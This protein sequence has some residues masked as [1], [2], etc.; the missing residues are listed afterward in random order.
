MFGN[1][2]GFLNFWLHG[3]FKYFLWIPL[4]LSKGGVPFALHAFI[5]VFL[6]WFS[7]Y[8][9]ELSRKNFVIILLLNYIIGYY[10]W[11]T[12]CPAP[13]HFRIYYKGG[14]G[15]SEFSNDDFEKFFKIGYALGLKNQWVICGKA[16]DEA[17]SEW[18]FL[19]YSQGLADLGKF[20]YP[21]KVKPVLFDFLISAK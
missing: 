13:P 20:L 1:Q 5:L 17:Q 12:V 15:E 21:F 19:G 8:A 18:F 16:L 7:K 6:Y 2:V 4:L 9:I 10:Y 11:E 14:R 3:G